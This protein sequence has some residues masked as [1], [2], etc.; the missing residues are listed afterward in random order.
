MLKLIMVIGMKKKQIKKCKV[1]LYNKNAFSL[2][3]IMVV[4]ATF[5]IVALGVFNA[6]AGGRRA[7]EVSAV[8]I[9]L[10][11]Q[12]RKAMRALTQELSQAGVSSVNINASNDQIIFK[13]PVSFSA[14]TIAW[15]ANIQYFLGGI[16]GEELMRIDTA[17]G[18]TQVLAQHINTL[19]FSQPSVDIIEI[20][21][22]AAKQSRQ[23]DNLQMQL[24]SQV[25]LRNR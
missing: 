18:Q 20:G 1:F 6:L 22:L 9:D 2:V 21:L 16:N 25:A 4:S 23:G 17:T 14:G 24:V 12:T 8:Q 13:V 3:E 5:V 7:Y 19:F 15:S 11:F 10:H